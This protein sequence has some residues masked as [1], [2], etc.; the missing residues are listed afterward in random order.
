MIGENIASSKISEKRTKVRWVILA[1][2]MAATANNYL[3][4]ASMSIAAPMIQEEFNL[5][6]TQIGYV[7]GAFQYGYFIFYMLAG[8]IIDKIGV[9]FG[10]PLIT[11]VWSM[12]EAVMALAT[13]LWQFVAL[14]ILLG[15][16]EG[17]CWPSCNKVVSEWFPKKERPL[18][19]GLFDSGSKIGMVISPIILTFT[20]VTFGWRLTF[21]L[22]AAIPGIIWIFFWLLI[23][24][25]PEKHAW[26]NQV[27]LRY[28]QDDA[29]QPE[30]ERAVQSKEVKLSWIQLLRYPQLWGVIILNASTIFTWFVLSTWLPK[31]FIDTRGVEFKV[32]GFYIALPMIGASIGNILGGV[33]LSWLISRPNMSVTKA[34]RIMVCICVALMACL[35]PAAY[36]KNNLV[37]TFLIAIVGIGYSA[38]ATNIL[39]SISDFVSRNLVA[40][41]TGIQATGAIFL[42]LPLV[43]YAGWIVEHYGYNILFLA[44]AFLPLLSIV[45]SFT[46][47]RRFQLIE[48]KNR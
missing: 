13:R 25:R 38:H 21:V 48:V 24:R 20:V 6:D 5:S 37:S 22:A 41:F 33:F 42:T 46:L 3:D 15:A 14:R 36:V 45:V 23:Y 40:S 43:T 39:S 30:E 28:I 27:E 12:V 11:F 7:F 18:A 10:F 47:I 34:R 4:R 44:A 26:I 16:G 9:R 2:L 8:I 17:G 35:V 29:D 19:C 32:V 1:L 31:Y